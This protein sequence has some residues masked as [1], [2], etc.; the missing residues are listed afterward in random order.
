LVFEAPW[1]VGRLSLAGANWSILC[2]TDGILDAA[3]RASRG[4]DLWSLDE[5]HQRH[6]HLDA[7]DLCQRLLNEVAVPRSSLTLPDDQTVLAIRWRESQ[8]TLP[9]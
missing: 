9:Q 2:C 1:E 8:P 3:I 5:F 4:G 6:Q 7:E